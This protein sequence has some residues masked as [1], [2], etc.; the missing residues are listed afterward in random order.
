MLS[1]SLE[2]IQWTW[3]GAGI[4]IQNGL[5]HCFW[6]F[7][8]MVLCSGAFT[9]VE[10]GVS[11]KDQCVC[12][13]SLSLFLFF[14][15]ACLRMWIVGSFLKFLAAWVLISAC[16]L[17]LVV[18]SKDY[19]FL[20]PTSVSLWW[21]L[22]SMELGLSGRGSVVKAYR[23]SCSAAYG[24][25]LDLGSNPCPLYWRLDSYSPGK[26]NYRLLLMI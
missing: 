6:F 9:Y 15:H 4:S 5:T 25:F 2:I 18:V 22:L 13:L 14:S 26:P 1:Q 24:I 23:L 12:D 8:H 10:E 20:L 3:R 17:S 16:Q 11:L 21:L 19:S 7:Q